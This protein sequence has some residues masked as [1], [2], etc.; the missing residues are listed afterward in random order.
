MDHRGATPLLPYS[1]SLP[2]CIT[3]PLLHCS[4]TLPMIDSLQPCVTA[5]SALA[6]LYSVSLNAFR[7]YVYEEKGLADTAMDLVLNAAPLAVSR[8][9][10]KHCDD[11]IVCN[12][13]ECE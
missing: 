4:T 9:L 11:A 12:V 8:L 5:A 10:V 1:P 2:H 13:S 3:S 7:H 6:L